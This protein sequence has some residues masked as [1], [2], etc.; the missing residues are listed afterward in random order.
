MLGHSYTL[1]PYE[2]PHITVSRT[3]PPVREGPDALDTLISGVELIVSKLPRDSLTSAAHHLQALLE[4][5]NGQHPS[6]P[7][8]PVRISPGD[9]RNPVDY[10][11]VSV[12]PDIT[13]DP[14]PDLLEKVRGVL[15]SVH[16]LQAE[17]KVGNGPDRTRRIY[18][19]V[20]SFALA[21]TLQPN[22]NDYLNKQ[23]CP[24]QCSFVSKAMNC[25]TY[26]LL[27]RTSVDKLVRNPPVIDHQTLFPSTPHYIQP[28]YGLEVAILGTKDV[29]GAIPVLDHYIRRK[30]GDVIASS[31]LAFNGDAYCVVFKTWVQT[32]RFLSDPFTAFKSGLGVSHLVTHA[33]PALLY[34]LN[35]IGLLISAC[36]PGPLKRTLPSVASAS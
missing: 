10:V 29:L 18:I 24:F 8:V 22:L 28:V 35:T 12:D 36:P 17:W 6:D 1:P 11:F 4:E 26:D 14:R 30:Y 20:D 27:D 23:G 13:Q 2:E 25:I 9:E 31:R 21:E 5:Y 15:T 33:A 34:V 3:A 7:L 19:H 16:S 32:L